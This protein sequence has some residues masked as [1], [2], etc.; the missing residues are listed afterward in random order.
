MYIKTTL[1][2]KFIRKEDFDDKGRTPTRRSLLW[3][4]S[5]L[6]PVVRVKS[7]NLGLF[8]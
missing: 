5:N 1:Y 8:Y 3:V 7:S 4:S 6:S 2:S